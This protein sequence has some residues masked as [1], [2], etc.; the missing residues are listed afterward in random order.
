MSDRV[1]R[2]TS[3]PP[4]PA[5]AVDLF[6][7][8]LELAR[9]YVDLLCG[10]G[11]ERGLL[12]P[13][14][15]AV[16]WER[17]ILNCAVVAAELP[18]GGTVADIGSGAGLPGLVWA[19][20]RPDL[21]ITLVEPLLRRARFLG[22]AVEALGLANVSVLRARAGDLTGSAVFT[23]VT[24]RAVAPLDRLVRWCLPLVGDGGGLY[25]FKGRSAA[26][27]LAKT[28]ATL[29]AMNAFSAD[30]KTYGE[31]VV[32]PPATVVVVRPGRG[33]Q[34]RTS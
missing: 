32:I 21:V 14:E 31:G 27:E 8:R 17:H 11:V 10:P 29:R 9:R 25:A 28:R 4:P 3:P 18:A 26:D 15:A 19:V 30:L 33:R 5:A 20:Q 2:E 24:A 34:E 12:G 23:V 1:S 7:R 6:G 13:R 16:V 22:E